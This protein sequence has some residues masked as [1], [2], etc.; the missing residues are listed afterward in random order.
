MSNKPHDHEFLHHCFEKCK[1]IEDNLLKVEVF[2]KRFLGNDEEEED[3]K[4]AVE[5]KVE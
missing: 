5:D 1:L 2:A 3:S 4:M